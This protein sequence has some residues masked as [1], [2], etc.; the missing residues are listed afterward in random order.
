MYFCFFHCKRNLTQAPDPSGIL[1]QY[2]F[3]RYLGPFHFY[4]KSYSQWQ[5]SYLLQLSLELY[6]SEKQKN[7]S[8]FPGASRL[9]QFQGFSYQSVVASC[10]FQ[11]L[12]SGISVWN[13]LLDNLLG[14]HLWKAME[15]SR[16]LNPAYSWHL[17][18]FRICHKQV[19]VLWS[20]TFVMFYSVSSAFPTRFPNFDILKLV[21]AAFSDAVSIFSGVWDSSKE[22]IPESYPEV[23]FWKLDSLPNFRNKCYSLGSP[24]QTLQPSTIGSNFP[25]LSH[26]SCHHYCMLTFIVLTFPL[27][28]NYVD[29]GIIISVARTS[30]K[31][32]FTLSLHGY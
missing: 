32:L 9:V 24:E 21:L 25:F 1:L 27:F 16:Q 4:L 26:V 30:G 5:Y 11:F 15:A 18:N 10:L 31:V 23:P 13:W 28:T 6:N 14:A 17:H 12:T 19:P 8:W 2:T 3:T 22:S 7:G 20:P 29:L